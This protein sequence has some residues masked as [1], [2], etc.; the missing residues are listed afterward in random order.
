[1]ISEYYAMRADSLFP[2][3]FMDLNM[4]VMNLVLQEKDLSAVQAMQLV[5]ILLPDRLREELKR[6]I[7]FMAAA[8][9]DNELQLDKQVIIPMKTLKVAWI[10]VLNNQNNALSPQTFVQ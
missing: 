2:E 4:S 1:M 8:A 10:N 7:K 3:R 5:M 6:L 9:E